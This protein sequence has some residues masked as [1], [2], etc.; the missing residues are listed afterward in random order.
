MDLEN[1]TWTKPVRPSKPWRW[2]YQVFGVGHGFP[3]V[4]QDQAAKASHPSQD[5]LLLLQQHG[6]V[7][8]LVQVLDDRPRP[9]AWDGDPYLSRLVA[10]LWVIDWSR[11]QSYCKATLVL[12]LPDV[13]YVMSDN[14]LDLPAL[15]GFQRQ[16]QGSTGLQ[17]FQVHVRTQLQLT[18]SG[19]A[20][21]ADA[22]KRNKVTA[23]ASR[24]THGLNGAPCSTC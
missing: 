19:T 13:P 5:D 1:L 14:A 3:P 18:R 24:R 2:A 15:P 4:W 22:H 23:A 11:P 21:L 12:G 8:H 16:W 20:T 6:Y 9:T 7:T 17:Q 10:V